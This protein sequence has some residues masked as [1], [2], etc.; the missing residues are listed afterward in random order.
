MSI[1]RLPFRLMFCAGL[2]AGSGLLHNI[3]AQQ[4]ISVVGRGWANNSVNTVV[5]RKNSLVSLGNT[6]Y[7]A[8][9]NKDSY[10]VLGKRILPAGKWTLKRTIYKG[11]TADAHNA[12]S[13]MVDGAGFLHLAWDQHNNTLRYCRSI[14]PGSLEMTDKIPMTG[15]LENHVTYPEFYRLPDG[16]L[17]FLY[18]D[19]ASG[20]GNLVINSYNIHSRQWKQLHNNLIDG[21]E[22]R[23][24]YWQACT[25]KHGS[26]HISW[27][28]RETA[29]VA[30]NH[31]LCYAVSADGG[32]TWMKSTGEKYRLPITVASAEYVCRIPEKTALINQTSMYADD[33]GHP[34]V[35]GYWQEQTDSVPQYHVIYNIGQYWK[36]LNLAFRK[37][38]F[39]LGGTGT[40]RVPISR[41]QIVS[42]KKGRSYGA[43]LIFRD[44]ERG[45]GVSVATSNNVNENK[46]LVRDLLKQNTGSW[47]P[48]YDTEWWKQ[49]KALYLF[50]Q[51]TDQKDSEGKADIAP[52]PVQILYW[53]PPTG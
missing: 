30:S 11:N 37:T 9:Y 27:V 29:D 32:A 25:D 7:I 28:W 23:S 24:A 16:N 26:L 33:E 49:K 18:R 34:F 4:K 3:A 40:K 14:G 17:V 47:E 21:Q 44:E 38:A 1:R 13:I 19:G 45:N 50:L 15:K 48:S 2:L 12:I 53:V 52:Q 8:Y 5:F 46:W 42:W 36:V 51:F 20:K 22:Q 35:A 43:A 31:D 41:P 6:Q 39:T 10:V